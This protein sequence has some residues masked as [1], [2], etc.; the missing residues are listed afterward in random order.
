HTLHGGSDGWHQRIWN[1]RADD[2]G[3]AVTFSLHSPDM[4]QGFPGAAD[5]EV[6][7]RLTDDNAVHISY[8]AVSDRETVFNLTNH[9]YFNLSG[10]G[11]GD[12]LEHWLRLGSAQVTEVDA[13]AIPTGKLL[14]VGGTALDFS[15][16]K[17]IGRD[18][19]SDEQQ[20]RLVSGFD[21][22]YAIGGATGCVRPPGELAFVAEARSE[23]TGISME[24]YSD[25]PGVQLYTGNYLDGSRPGKGGRVYKRNGGFC[26]E[27]Q[28]YPDS[29]HHAHFPSAHYRAGEV[30]ESETVY[31]F[32]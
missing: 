15:Q 20:V 3:N 21:H 24:V 27:T 1:A 9:S 19:G 25:M 30:F 26:L 22:N 10:A 13:D 8:R 6:R 5:V 2:S 7:Y 12:I 32:A 23:A 16:G 18:I 28:F 17:K 29:P 31:S 4:D 14:D 11:A